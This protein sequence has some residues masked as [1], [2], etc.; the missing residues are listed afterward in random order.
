MPLA[1]PVVR[2]ALARDLEVVGDVEL[3]ARHARDAARRGARARDR[4]HRHER[5][6]HG[7][8]AHRRDVPGRP[9]RHRRR[10]EHLPAVLDA[11]VARLEAGRIPQGWV[12]ELSSFQLETTS[13]LRADAAT[14]L[15]LSEDHLDRYAGMDG[16]RGREGAR[17]RG[18]GGQI[19]NRNDPRSI[20][21]GAPAGAP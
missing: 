1:E 8:G 11:L 13:S 18:D 9:A 17:V 14:M 5:Q 19:L 16:V 12:L 4:D 20:G 15:N 3:F 6:D 10:R 2:A 21:M 7:H